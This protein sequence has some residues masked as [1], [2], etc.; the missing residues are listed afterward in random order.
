M[1]MG[2][3][4]PLP[5]DATDGRSRAQ[6]RLCVL[7]MSLV[8]VA[9]AT[10]AAAP[11]YI[12]DEQP[13]PAS[14]EDE[15]APMEAVVAVEPPLPSVFPRLKKRL[16]TA[17]P[18]WRDTQLRLHPRLYH[19]DRDR[20]GADDSVALAYGGWL[21]YNS[22]WWRD[23]L[24]FNASLYTTQRAYG[25]G[26]KDGTLLLK[27][28][29]QGFAVL[30]KANV[31]LK[32][33]DTVSTTLYRQSFNLP[34]LNRN[35]SRMVPNTFEAYSL[36]KEPADNW[37][38]LFSQ[39]RQ[40][41]RRERDDF[42]SMSQ[43]AG[44]SDRDEPLTV[45]AARY[46][47]SDDINIGATSQYAWE[48]M[49]TFYTEANA[50]WSFAENR[51]LRLAGQYTDQRSVGDEI[52]G[53]FDA[54]IQPT[55][56]LGMLINPTE[57]FQ[58]E[59]INLTGV[60]SLQ[61]AEFV[62]KLRALVEDSPHRGL[63]VV[64]HGFREAYPSALRKTAFLGHVLDINAPVLLFDWPG[65][66]G[67][68]L[69]GYRRAH[70]VARASGTELARTLELVI[71]DIQ[72]ERLWLIANSMGGQVVAD[73]FSVLYA[74][75][76]LADAEPEIEDV[77]LTAPDVD[78]DEFNERIKQEITALAKSL[79]VYVSSNDR[80]LL[81]SRLVNR[82]ARHGES[83]LTADQLEEA[84]RIGHLIEPHSKLITLVDVTPVNRTR[85]FNNFSLETP[86]FF[87]DLYLRLINSEMPR[88]RLLYQI[89]AP[90]GAV[91][92]VLTQGR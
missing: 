64:V 47:F 61:Q 32:L 72:P 54:D 45:G 7:V 62:E 5:T 36:I 57:W 14:V 73:A 1:T 78:Q 25:P 31:E 38:F 76:D 81:V 55:L 67:S 69:R 11:E 83:T 51:A 63:L 66:Q 84:V 46:D 2:P 6:S 91:Y 19:F 4:R 26:D 48:F 9:P 39:V 3:H 65:N 88:S 53:A 34:Y 35:D 82:G 29:Q 30:G 75:A 50:V 49:N 12:V 33:S 42:I 56:G 22:G 74:E 86:E 37:V 28:G 59:E 70:E 90:D 23:R 40:M 21:A 15:R 71:R 80:A 44:F 17:A 60:R 52:G 16:E 87:D 20:E 85:N 24:R 77:V 27:E 41:K 13:A 10:R 8:V 92:S 18:V 43:A 89:E 79:T 58:N 68:S